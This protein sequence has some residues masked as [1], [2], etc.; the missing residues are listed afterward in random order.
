MPTASYVPP[1]PSALPPVISLLRVLMQGDG[2]LLSLLPAAAYTMDVGPLG[3]SRRQILIVNDP[4]L[5]RPILADPRDVFPKNDLMVDALA[6][7]VGDSMFVSSGDVW[8]QQRRMVDPAFSHMR[9]Q[10][11]YGSMVAAVDAIEQTMT[12]HARKAV[13]RSPWTWR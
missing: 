1:R 5:V 8:R 7:L 9:L 6:P 4:Q 12:A 3:Y 10:E 2:D 11:G 13:K